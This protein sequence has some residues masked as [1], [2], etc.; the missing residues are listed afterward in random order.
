MNS[1]RVL[2][3]RPAEWLLDSPL[4]PYV[5]SFTYHFTERGYAPS[6]IAN[7]PGY[8]SHFARWMGQCQM[9]IQRIDEDLVRQFLDEHLPH[10][11]CVG[12]VCRTC[13]FGKSA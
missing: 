7:Y 11:D 10:C 1:T 9:E 6:T 3:R 5:E 8:G 2:P 13:P 12:P 4:A